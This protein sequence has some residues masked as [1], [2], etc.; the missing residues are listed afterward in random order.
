MTFDWKR[1][2]LLFVFA[3]ILG[4]ALGRWSAH[5]DS[6]HGWRKRTFDERFE[7]FSRKLDLSAAQRSRARVILETRRDQARALREETRPRWEELRARTAAEIRKI[8]SPAQIPAFEAME[9]RWKSKRAKRRKPEAEGA[10]T[11]ESR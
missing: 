5:L 4:A 1:A 2:A 3:L 11:P 10:A 7:D 9:G 8:L 6:R